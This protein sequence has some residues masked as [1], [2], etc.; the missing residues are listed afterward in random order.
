MFH[1]SRWPLAFFALALLLTP[2][3][4]VL[5]A[6]PAFGID[7]DLNTGYQIT[8]DDLER[9][10]QHEGARDLKGTGNAFVEAGRKYGINPIYIMAHAAWE[11]GWGSSRIARDKK[12]L[13]GYGAYDNCPYR[14]AKTFQSYEDGVNFI[15][16]RVREDYLNKGGDYYKGATLKGM[17]TYYATD[18][19]WKH[20]IAEIMNRFASFY[21]PGLKPGTPGQASPA[22]VDLALDELPPQ[23]GD[24]PALRRFRL[25]V[26]NQGEGRARGVTIGMAADGQVLQPQGYALV[27]ADGKTPLPEM[28]SIYNPKG[29]PRALAAYLAVLEPGEEKQV[30]YLARA[31]K[32]VDADAPPVLAWLLNIDGVFRKTLPESVPDYKTRPPQPQGRIEASLKPRPGPAAKGN[33]AVPDPQAQGIIAKLRGLSN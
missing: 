30:I 9:F 22:K 21:G 2:L 13:F 20:G 19:N 25:R 33:T 12:N 6:S 15:M 23:A 26:H 14:C 28:E 24:D 8:A 16:E 10:F 5:A 7:S 27:A 11:S 17:N 4:G 31:A 32:E 18:K 3:S 29:A 1:P